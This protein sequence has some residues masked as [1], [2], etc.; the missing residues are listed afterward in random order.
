MSCCRHEIKITKKENVIFTNLQQVLRGFLPFKVFSISN[1]HSQEEKAI[2]SKDTR[3]WSSLMKVY[4]HIIQTILYGIWEEAIWKSWF[5]KLQQFSCVIK[6]RILN[7][8]R[9]MYCIDKCHILCLYIYKFFSLKQC[10]LVEEI[11]ILESEIGTNFNLS[12]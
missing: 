6:S 11:C 2:F 12:T 10:G 4:S 1:L 7:L 8:N 9:T 3:K 5:W